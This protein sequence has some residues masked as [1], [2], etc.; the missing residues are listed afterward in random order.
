MREQV[1]SSRKGAGLNKYHLELTSEE[2][3]LADQIDFRE[4]IPHHED[5]HEIYKANQAPIIALLKL[6]VAR[7]A[8]PKKRTAYWTSPELK[9]GRM[10]GSH[11]DIFERNGSKGEEAYTHPHFIPFL[12]YFLYGANLPQGAIDEFEAQVGNP[13][14]FSGSDII[15]LAK[16]TRELVRK[17]GLKDYRDS[18]EFM[19]LALDLGLNTYNANSVRSA[20]VE[21]A[22]R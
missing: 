2:Q 18:D 5:G 22:R 8:I 13:E 7:N 20:A 21:A 3:A 12:R 19:K 9:P 14:W 10:K 6:L 4:V 1:F 15:A 17:Y 11:R 16:K